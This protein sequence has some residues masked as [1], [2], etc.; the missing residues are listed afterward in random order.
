VR[1]FVTPPLI[2]GQA[3]VYDVRAIW[4]EDGRDV[5]RDRRVRVRA[6]EQ[7]DVDFTQPAPGEDMPTLRTAPRFP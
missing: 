2:P 6:G 3:Y 7:V 5:T 4:L 1:R